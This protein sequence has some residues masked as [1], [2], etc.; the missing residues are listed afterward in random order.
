MPRGPGSREHVSPEPVPPVVE[1]PPAGPPLAGPGPAPDTAAAV[2]GAALPAAIRYAELLAGPGVERGLIGP[3][4]ASRIWDRHLL[5][6]AAIAGL[7]PADGWIVDVGSGAGLPGVVLA[8]LVPSAR[9]TLVEPMAR[10]VTFLEECVAE[11]G[12]ANVEV[13]RGRAEE[14]AGELAA[15]MVTA[16]AVAPLAK[17]AGLCAGLA[18]PGGLVVAMKGSSAATELASAATELAQLGVADARVAQ[19]GSGTG[20]GAAT[21]VMFTVAARR[22]ERGARRNGRRPGGGLRRRSGSGG[23]RGRPAR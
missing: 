16:R 1:R 18:R 7:A 21:V 8:L 3:A 20:P 14:L 12:L 4:E 11:L 2:F 23:R 15:D 10:R 6:S 5:N 9:L 13:R 19:V 22:T 17:L